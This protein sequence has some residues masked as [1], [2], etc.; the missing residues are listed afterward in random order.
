MEARQ[1]AERAFFTPC[2]AAPLLSVFSVSSAPLL[3][4]VCIRAHVLQPYAYLF[5]LTLRLF[6]TPS[7]VRDM[8]MRDALFSMVDVL[9]LSALLAP[10]HFCILT[11]PHGPRSRDS[12][13]AAQRSDGKLISPIGRARACS[14]PRAP[15]LE[16]ARAPSGA[17]PA[18]KG[19]TPSCRIRSAASPH[20]RRCG[21]QGKCH[22]SASRAVCTAAQLSHTPRPSRPRALPLVTDRRAPVRPRT[23]LKKRMRRNMS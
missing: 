13:A 15:V 5:A 6:V 3:C 21:A 14:S 1:N 9:W 16:E 7:G 17:A 18:P 10:S 19:A 8:H 22:R 23:T 12:V 2:F 4:R 20:A 11:Q